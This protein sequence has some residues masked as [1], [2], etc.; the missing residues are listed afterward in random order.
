MGTVG[1]VISHLF[2]LPSPRLRRLAG[3]ADMWSFRCLPPPAW[4]S[5]PQRRSF[6]WGL[7]PVLSDFSKAFIREGL[8]RTLNE[9]EMELFSFDLGPSARNHQGVLPLSRPL[10][11]SAIRRYTE[12]ALKLVRRYFNGPLAAENYNFY[13]TGFYRHVTEPDFI[14]KFLKEFDLGLV[15]DL[16][17]AAVT[18][19]NVG[20]NLNDYL[21]AL[22]LE[23]TTEIHISSPWLPGV[24][25]LMAVD[26]HGSPGKREWKWLENLFK[27]ERLPMGTPVFVEYYQ[28]LSKLE[29]AQRCLGEIMPGLRPASDGENGMI[30]QR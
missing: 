29:K 11:Q 6:H 2:A 28:D 18:A 23:R 15:L 17:H 22:P 1:L 16:A 5:G 7:G 26:S 20:L 24:P 8:E 3:T 9:Y 10:G 21:E 27:S 19:H 14:E 12:A 13:P 4:L 25:G 30:S